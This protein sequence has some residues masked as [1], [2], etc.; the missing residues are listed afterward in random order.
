ME[1]KKVDFIKVLFE[2]NFLRITEDIGNDTLDSLI[3]LK[4][5]SYVA[6]LCGTAYTM[7]YTEGKQDAK[8][9]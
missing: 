4:L 9:K 1:E 8:N 5:A 3:A 6:N 2:Q 7:G